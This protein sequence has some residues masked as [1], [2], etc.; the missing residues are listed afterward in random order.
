[1]TSKV[2]NA[3]GV[4]RWL[5]LLETCRP[6]ALEV[7]VEL[8]QR[9]REV[10]AA[11]A[12]PGGS[13]GGEPAAS[14]RATGSGVVEEPGCRRDEAEDRLLLSLTEA[15]CEPLRRRDRAARVRS[16]LASSMRFDPSWVLEFLDSRHADV[17]AEGMPGFGPN[18]QA[19][20]DVTLWRRLLESPHDDVRLFLISELES[21]VAGRDVDR[22]A[23]LGARCRTHC[24]CS[25]H[26][27]S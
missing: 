17:R 5:E 8:M 21:R 14:R 4:E 26:R 12:R 15:E 6:E 19:R 11:F 27:C 24:G 1:M 7:I 13:I 16:L 2:S 22:I 3:L 18:R 20:D 23:S 10:G 25:G 9:A